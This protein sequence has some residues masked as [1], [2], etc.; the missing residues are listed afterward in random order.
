MIQERACPFCGLLIILNDEERKASHQ[1]P[2][3][4]E[5]AALVEKAGK[6]KVITSIEVRGTDGRLRPFVGLKN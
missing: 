5:F 4:P 2:E 3:C 6:G 1:A